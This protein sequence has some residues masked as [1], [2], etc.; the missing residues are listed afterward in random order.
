MKLIKRP[1]SCIPWKFG[2]LVFLKS[3]ETVEFLVNVYYL[4]Q[5][6]S[7]PKQKSL[8]QNDMLPFEQTPE[9][10]KFQDYAKGSI[11]ILDLKDNSKSHTFY[12]ILENVFMGVRR[13]WLKIT[14]I[15]LCFIYSFQWLHKRKTEFDGCF[16]E[17]QHPSI[18]SQPTS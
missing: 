10:T 16:L 13:F 6:D 7:H 5:E 9:M 14:A 4:A 1:G 8:K 3:S 11:S 15:Q 12:S 18:C 2:C 17:R